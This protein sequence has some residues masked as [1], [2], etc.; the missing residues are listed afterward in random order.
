M[1]LALRRPTGLLTSD[2]GSG[3]RT[4]DAAFAGRLSR[5]KIHHHFVDGSSPFFPRSGWE[6]RPGG[7]GKRKR[8]CAPDGAHRASASKPMTS[9]LATSLNATSLVG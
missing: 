5:P 6:N 3:H 1:A 8:A 4:M 7:L 2:S 9:L